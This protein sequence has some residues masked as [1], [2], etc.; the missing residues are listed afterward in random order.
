[1]GKL[2]FFIQSLS[3]VELSGGIAVFGFGSLAIM[4]CLGGTGPVALV[5][6]SIS[7][8]SG[9]FSFFKLYQPRIFLV[10]TGS[11]T[12]GFLAAGLGLIG[13]RDAT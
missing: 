7:G 8:A 2:L 6:A 3:P 4:V 12:F 1:M 10:G 13:W 9:V 5:N 11:T